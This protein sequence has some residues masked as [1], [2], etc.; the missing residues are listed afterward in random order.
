MTEKADKTDKTGKKTGR[1]PSDEQLQRKCGWKEMPIG[2]TITRAA[3]ALENKTG[4]WRAFRPVVDAKKCIN[5]GFCTA[6]CPDDAVHFRNGKREEINLD[7]CKGC[8]VCANECPVKCIKM[9]MK[10]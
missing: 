3:S 2:G 5:C 7:Y 1:F 6:Y 4:S 8:G 9:E 10:K